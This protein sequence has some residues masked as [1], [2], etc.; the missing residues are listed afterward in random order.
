MDCGK[1]YI[2]VSALDAIIHMVLLLV[3][4]RQT[5]DFSS[6]YCST[7]APL[8]APL[9]V[10]E[11]SMY[12][13]KRLELSLRTVFAFPKAMGVETP[14]ALLSSYTFHNKPCVLQL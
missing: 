11:M 1:K 3:T 4:W 8:I 9:L 10:N 7:R 6:R 2:F 13:P 14:S 12:F 5:R